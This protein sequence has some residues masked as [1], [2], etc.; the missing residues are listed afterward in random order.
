MN[1]IVERRRQ[2]LQS[3][4]IFIIVYKTI[5]KEDFYKKNKEWKEKMY[6]NH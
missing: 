6:V 3:K 2:S 1:K 5:N 4:L